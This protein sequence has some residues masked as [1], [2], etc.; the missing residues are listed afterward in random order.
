MTEVAYDCNGIG[1][2]EQQKEG[3][4]LADVYFGLIDCTLLT[5]ISFFL[6]SLDFLTIF[7]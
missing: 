7:P 2:K 5:G 6:E 1:V 3:E 4:L